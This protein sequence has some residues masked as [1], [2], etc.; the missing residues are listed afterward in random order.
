VDG[1][2][3]GSPRSADAAGVALLTA[4]AVLVAHVLTTRTPPSAP[5]SLL[6]VAVVAVLAAAM[7]ARAPTATAGVAALAQLAGHGV[8]ALTRPSGDAPGG[9]LSVVGRGA[10]LGIRY[11][12]LRPSGA[13]PPGTVQATPALVAVV[14]AVAAGL[15]VLAG[16]ALVAALAALL[17]TSVARAARR[18]RSLAAS[19]L[20]LL[21]L[22]DRAPVPVHGAPACPPPAPV[23]TVRR[24]WPGTPTRRGPPAPVVAAG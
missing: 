6:V 21:L 24:W 9:C 18:V 13:C 15:A 5:A 16:Q 14:A 12:L 17:V 4:P 3:G 11:G 20:P 19:V 1:T 10:D 23:P 2:A 8:L 7:P 22:L